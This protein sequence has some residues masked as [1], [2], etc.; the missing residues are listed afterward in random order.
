MDILL[1]HFHFLRPWMFLLLLPLAGVLYRLR[2]THQTWGAWKKICS[3]ELL[4]YLQVGSNSLKQAHR[5]LWLIAL[6]GLLTVVALAGPVWQK[7]PQPLYRPAS[8][9]VI[10]LDLSRSMDAEDVKP[11][12]LTRAKQKLTDLFTLRKEGQTA[13]IAF[14]GSAHTVTPLTEDNQTML[15]QLRELSTNIMPK[16]GGNIDTAIEQAL[17]LFKQTS[18]QHGV[19]L[20]MTDSS[21]YSDAVAKQL[22]QAGHR[23]DVIGIGSREGAPIPDRGEGATGGFVNDAQGNIV[24]A[25][26]DQQR[27]QRLADMGG[28][29]FHNLTLDNSDIQPLLDQ[30][31]R[32][33]MADVKQDKSATDQTTHSHDAWHEEGPWLLLLVIPFALMGFRRGILILACC[34]FMQP[35][36]V[37]AQTWND[38]W[39]TKN[40]QAEELMQ[41]KKYADAAKTFD[42]PAWRAA[43]HYRQGDYAAAL[44][45]FDA[46][47]QPT[48]DDQYNRANALAHLGR[49]DE[50]ITAY[51]EIL[52]ND[53]QYND[54][55]A[56]KALL[57]KLKQQ[58]SQKDSHSN[59]SNKK[60]A[61]KNQKQGSGKGKGDAK[62]QQQDATNQKQ[63]GSSKPQHQKGEKNQQNS[64][65]KGNQQKQPSN[66]EAQAAKDEEKNRKQAE[67]LKKSPK[68]NNDTKK[69]KIGTNQQHTL[70]PD[71]LKKLESQQAFEQSMRRI[72]DDPG[73]LLRRKFLYQYQQQ[74]QAGKAP[75]GATSW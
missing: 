75:Q 5:S 61:S 44:K 73:G 39:Q 54:A 64:A 52:K 66:P 62:N 10:L 14:A 37:Q 38:L 7:L 45:D 47:T 24:I 40:S 51:D 67:Q 6:A 17:T 23:L 35:H 55:K 18:V 2:Q 11:S 46:I 49:L 34:W 13:L 30:L 65:Q 4:D 15:S 27:L 71:E 59:K 36:S 32:R 58:N 21:Q 31:E 8:A 72:P 20:L 60:D 63:D 56:N 12:R 1:T 70:S 74:Q 53:D 29:F 9:L 25:K 48:L 19:V 3:P 28:G 33:S 50:A 43:A 26:L 57:E 69:Q 42:D 41:Q 22:T 68:Q 16:Q